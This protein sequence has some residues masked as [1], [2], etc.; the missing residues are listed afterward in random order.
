MIG[1]KNIILSIIII[2]LGWTTFNL[3]RKVEKDLKLGLKVMFKI[4][5]TKH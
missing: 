5:S 1:Y 4:E 2:T 3:S